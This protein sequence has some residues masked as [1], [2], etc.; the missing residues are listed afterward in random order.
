MILL[1]AL[2]EGLRPKATSSS[3]QDSMKF[4][5]TYLKDHKDQLHDD[6]HAKIQQDYI[7]IKDGNSIISDLFQGMFKSH[8]KCN[9]CN[10]TSKS[11]DSFNICSLPIPK[12]SIKVLNFYFQ[13]KNGELFKFSCFYEKQR[14]L[15]IGDLKMVLL[16]HFNFS[17]L[18]PELLIARNADAYKENAIFKDSCPLENFQKL[19]FGAKLLIRELSDYE[20]GILEINKVLIV[21]SLKIIVEITKKL[22]NMRDFKSFLIFDKTTTL[23][24][25]HFLIYLYI[26]QQITSESPNET[27][28]EFKAKGLDVL[29]YIIK[30]SREHENYFFDYQKTIEI[31]V[32]LDS[33]QTLEEFI[34]MNKK[35]PESNFGLDIQFK[36]LLKLN[37]IIEE[38][39]NLTDEDIPL[40]KSCSIFDC[41]NLMTME[42]RLDE[43]NKWFCPNCKTNQLC[44]KKL[45][46]YQTGP[47][48]I[49]H[50]KRHQHVPKR[51]KITTKIDF[52]INGLDL[53][54]Y[55][56]SGENEKTYDLFAICNHY[57]EL[58]QG[59]YTALCLNERYGK[60]FHFDDEK[61][62][63]V[64]EGEMIKDN[65]YILF[66]KRR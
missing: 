13:R 42:E 3:F 52:P 65:A 10:K 54:R 34:L 17:F 8:I 44:S 19:M 59:H 57:G 62:N 28:E 15:L 31:E 43:S 49:I 35:K 11:F 29:P 56:L 7:Q 39:L 30:V 24:L 6:K 55:I 40:N 22:L 16:S 36:S 32:P 26:K 9:V 45:E 64:N 27:F 53:S 21:V 33:N 60:W 25:V 38:K 4:Y 63:E 14:N 18:N 12:K 47:I 66:Y 37:K 1:D 46:I 51:K 23:D 58:N 61:V 50:F 20:T 2:H 41:L 5:D 48:L